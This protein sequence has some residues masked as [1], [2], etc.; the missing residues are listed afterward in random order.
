MPGTREDHAR[1]RRLDAAFQVGDL[2]ALRSEIGSIDGF[3]NV[4]ADPA[5]GLCLTYA[6]YHSPI[7]FVCELLEAGADPNHHEHDGFP[8]LFAALSCAVPGP[9]AVCRADV[10]DILEVLLAYGADVGLRGINDYTP[11]HVAAEQGNVRFVEILLARGADPNAITRIDEMETPLELAVR[12]GHREVADRLRPLTVRLD[13]ERA[14]RDGDI[15]TLSRMIRAGHDINARD[16]YGQTALMRAAH[17]GHREAVSW[18]IAQG[19]DLNHT[20]KFRLSALM[21]AVVA[22]RP[23]VARVLVAAGADPTIVGTGAPGFHGKTA[24]DLAEGRG[25]RRLAAFIRRRGS[26]AVD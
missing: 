2:A 24:A 7:G 25:D 19:A 10:A 17:A 18:L 11:L 16:G 4:V 14:S 6:I 1:Y 12:G 8:P 23:Q 26:G 21:L 20:S 22:G 9:G 15:S 13:W 3:P 5:I